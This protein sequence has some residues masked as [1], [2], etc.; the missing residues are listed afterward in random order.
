[1]YSLMFK[2]A[3]EK[4]CAGSDISQ[5]V[6]EAENR[7]LAYLYCAY[8]NH[9]GHLGKCYTREG[10]NCFISQWNTR[11]KLRANDD[12]VEKSDGPFLDTTS[13]CR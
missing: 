7:E 5:L 8:R 6:N 11:R 9:A 2:L 13:K 10:G 3:F 4:F 1:M 12:G